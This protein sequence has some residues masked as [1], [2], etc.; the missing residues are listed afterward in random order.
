MSARSSHLEFLPDFSGVHRTDLPARA[1]YAEGAGIF[2]I[3]PAGVTV[4]STTTALSELVTW[5]TAHRTPLIPRG[6]GSGMVGGNLGRGVVVDLTTLDGAPL[7]VNAEA[8]LARAGAAVSLRA[9]NEDARRRGLRL[10][11]DPSSARFATLGGMLSTNASG[12][13]AVRAG[14]VRDW[15]TA[16]EMITA[17]GAR[18]TLRRGAPPPETP[19]VERFLREAEPALLDARESVRSRYP[20]TLKNSSGYAIDRWLDSG[21][22]IDLVVGAEGTLGFITAAEWRLEPI[23]SSYGGVRAALHDSAALGEIVPALSRLIP[24]AVEYLDATFLGFV[25]EG[26][27]G[28]GGMLGKAGKTGEGGLLMVELEGE[29]SR[30]IQSRIEA[31]R[32]ILAPYSAEILAATERNALEQ[33]WSVRHAA[34]PMLAR[35]GEGRRSL[36]VIEDAC[37]PLAAMSHY[38]TAVRQAGARNRIQLVIF[39]H[40]GSGNLHVNLLP[41]LA[42]KDWKSRV[43]AIFEEVTEVVLQ[44]GGTP[45]GEHGDGRLRAHLLE[46]VYGAEIVRLFRLV[47]D[48]FDPLGILNPGIKLPS[49]D[50]QPFSD[51]K[52]G[53]DA[54]DLPPRIEAGLREIE[55]SAGY[56][57]SRLDLAEVQ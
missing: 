37:V 10:P 56:S 13:S 54:A 29:D 28:E 4:P 3:L 47:K 48:A 7:R 22:L 41:D 9:L 43:I 36:Q 34:S 40:A 15:V 35:L 27:T 32:R 33:L 39:G 45:S 21:D 17:D 38:I 49:P 6:A 20:R 26:K 51:L 50:F 16:V 11:P 5:A 52:V 42:E 44:L 23:P 18:M 14:S 46:R 57:Q 25:E 19:T 8:R 30:E 12:P 55:R 31:A 53:E 2:R 24:S 1:A